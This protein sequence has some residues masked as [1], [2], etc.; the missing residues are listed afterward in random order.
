[1]Y[2][3]I[4]VHSHVALDLFGADSNEVLLSMQEQGIATIVVGVDQASSESAVSCARAYD[5]VFA[6]IGVH[7]EDGKEEGFDASFYGRLVTNP[8][9][10]AVGECGLDYY[11]LS[12]EES[13]ARKESQKNL[14]VQQ[15]EFAL[16]HNKP[17]MIHG[18]PSKGSMDAYEDI[19]SIL[20]VY[21]LSHGSLLRGNVHFFVG[22]SEIAEQFFTRNFTVSFTG[23][24]TFAR[25]YD[26]VVTSAPQGMIQAETDS[27]YATPVPHRGKRNDPRYLPLIVAKLA[28]LRGESE[29]NLR[30]ALLANAE[31][32]FGP[33]K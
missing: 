24:V 13:G 29:E 6:T 5:N 1:M 4:D 21:V 7:P 14:F 26:G 3:Y 17:L 11:R 23:V 25:D 19:L 28:E 27:P 18:R 16:A 15:I 20:D 9:V 2:R 22:T 33:F 32:V 10:V 31:R 30:I 8:K 12:S